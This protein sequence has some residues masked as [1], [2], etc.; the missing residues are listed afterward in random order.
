MREKRIYTEL[1]GELKIRV[2]GSDIPKEKVIFTTFSTF[3]S[4]ENI[5]ENE[6]I[7]R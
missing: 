3:L 2:R 1:L 6:G 7:K 5:V 4:G